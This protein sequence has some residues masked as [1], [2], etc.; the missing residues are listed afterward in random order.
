MCGITGEVSWR[1]ELNT[2]QI[3]TMTRN[4]R[5]RGPDDAG[6][7]RSDNHNCILG[8]ARLSIIDLSPA[9]HQ[10][11][12]DPSTGNRIV[13]NGEIYNFQE[14]RKECKRDGYTFHSNTD[15]EVIL[16]LYRKHGIECL[17][18]LRGMFAFAIWDTRKEQLFIARDRVGKKPLNYAITSQ[19]LVFCSEIDPLVKHCDISKDMD[20][21]ALQLYLQL[22]YIPAPRTIY[23]QI[24]KLPPA[25]YAIYSRQGLLIKKYWNVDYRDK[26]KIPEQEALEAF[27]ETLTEATRLRMISDVPIGALLSGGVD[28]SVIVALMAKLAHE[29]VNTFSIGFKEQKYNELNY[30]A[31]V[32]EQYRTKHHPEVVEG[33][34][35]NVLSRIARH[36][37]EP[38]ADSS[39]IPS[40]YVCEYARK[41]VAVVLNGDGGDELLAGYP[42]Y[43]LSP[44]SMYTGSLLG[45]IY[46]SQWLSRN[47]NNL[48]NA[49]SILE[50]INR[51]WLVK[52]TNPEIDCF[53][54]RNFWGDTK[55]AKMLDSSY[56]N[57]LLNKWREVWLE[58]VRKHA[59][60]PVDRMLW[61][62]NNT[63]LPGDLLVKMDIASMQCGLETRSPFLDHEVIEFCAKLPV[64][65]KVRNR[66]G[67]YLLKRLAENYF[68]KD[69]VY[70]PKMGFG[71][72]LA[73][74]LR[75]PLQEITR[76]LLS[77]RNMTDPL[78]TDVVHATLCEFYDHNID[79]SSRIWALL[80]YSVW[81]KECYLA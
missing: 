41:H 81:K 1:A 39:A 76:D 6:V 50:K 58:D 56:D 14:R 32:A 60:N 33:R 67:K 22:Q 23:H 13:F 47:I 12:L 42:R 54:Y 80:M 16:A 18:Y 3:E 55:R 30:A 24:K 10:P 75:G 37:G 5:H 20:H 9:G 72:P 53:A 52:V 48:V 51:K 8:H 59:T 74:W 61:I 7:W 43:N 28:S 78:N 57:E 64:H 38:Y 70:R 49:K 66:T 35:Q 31:L 26:I 21:D 77:N 17:K 68:P 44:Y 69:F 11:M 73:D 25:H 63:Y 71:I 45:S 36:Y 79:H 27:E 62:D 4:I 40:F 19:G 29:P 34:V 65:Y 2:N 46:N 15:S